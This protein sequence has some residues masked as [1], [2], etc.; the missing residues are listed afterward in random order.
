MKDTGMTTIIAREGE[1]DLA[2]AR[3][4]FPRR[5][6][7]GGAAYFEQGEGEPVVLLH[8]VGMRLEAWAP[9]LG[10]LAR[11]HRVIAVDLPGHGESAKLRAGSTIE[12]FVAWFGRFLDDMAIEKANV[13]GHSMGA[14]ITGGAVATFPEKI[15]RAAYVCGVHRRDAAAKA[16]VLARAAAIPVNGVDRVGP[17]ARWFGDDPNHVEARELVRRFLDLVDVEAYGIAY[18]AFAAGDEVY[19]DSW[20]QVTC[21]VLF[22]TADGDPNSTPEMAQ[23]MAAMAPRGRARIISGHRHMVSLTAPETVNALMCEWLAR[24]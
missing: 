24:S 3:R 7:R 10:V 8:G 11:T 13:A 5:T 20:G 1:T 12:D 2:A 19:A 23:A 22:L 21:P 16:A 18:S 6:T 9:Q 4:I 17:L 15:A 14:M